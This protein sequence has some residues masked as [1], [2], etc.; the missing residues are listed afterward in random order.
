MSFLSR[1]RISR[2]LLLFLSTVFVLSSCSSLNIFSAKSS[3]TDN[4]PVAAVG[5]EVDAQADADSDSSEKEDSGE[6]QELETQTQQRPTPIPRP[7]YE[8]GAIIAPT[9]TP[10]G[11]PPLVVATLMGESNV[12][13]PIDGPAVVGVLAQIEQ[14]NEQ[15]GVLGRQISVVRFDTESRY[16]VVA[17]HVEEILKL[18]PDLVITSCD[19][20]FSLPLLRATEQIPI[21]TISPCDPDPRY[22]TGELGPNHFSLGVDPQALGAAGAKETIKRLGTQV[23]VLKDVTSPEALAFCEGFQNEYILAG[24]Q[25]LYSDQFNYDT[26]APLEDRLSD[27][28]RY[29]DID[30]VPIVLCSHVPGG[31]DAAPSVISMIRDVG[32]SGAIISGPR[33]DSPNWFYGVPQLGELMLITWSSTYG[34]DPN[35]K[36]NE[37]LAKAS[38]HI[39]TKPF[40]D[41]TPGA[42]T[43]L[44]AEAISIWVEAIRLAQSAQIPN[45]VSALASF[46][47]HP[48]YTGPLTFLRGQRS[49]Q[50]RKVRV[51]WVSD[52]LLDVLDTVDID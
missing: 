50:T 13:G 7:T 21:L 28:K 25:I 11:P 8:P 38:D 1:Y 52:G 44:G 5:N 15:G 34:N 32:L 14:I 26:P 10:E 43:I 2:I 40:S 51:L 30:N 46:H 19:T 42:T 24:G 18:Q 39:D 41:V 20:D 9:P 47:D 17:Q 35:P 37:L 29:G 31:L 36:V 6:K 48:S 3:E 16:S 22:N 45:V 4:E 23:I 49:D 33:L 27:R 12:M